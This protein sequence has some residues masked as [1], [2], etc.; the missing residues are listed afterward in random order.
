MIIISVFSQEGRPWC[1]M[2]AILILIHENCPTFQVSSIP[3]NLVL[4]VPLLEYFLRVFLVNGLSRAQN[5]G[6]T[7]Y[8]EF[9]TNSFSDSMKTSQNPPLLYTFLQRLCSIL[10]NQTLILTSILDLVPSGHPSSY[11]WILSRLDTISTFLILKID[12][13]HNNTTRG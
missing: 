6:I 12:K 13:I 10:H 3:S 5:T 9:W 4:G 8:L 11:E 2:A 7:S 1:E